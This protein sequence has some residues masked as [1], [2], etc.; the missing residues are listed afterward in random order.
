[1]KISNITSL[2]L[3]MCLCFAASA[4]ADPVN[5]PGSAAQQLSTKDGIL[6][7]SVNASFAVNE[8]IITLNEG[9]LLMR[10]KQ[11]CLVRAGAER[12]LIGPGGMCVIGRHDH[13]VTVRNLSELR[14][15]SIGVFMAD[16]MYSL[17]AAEE[18]VCAP[19]FQ[20]LKNYVLSDNVAR[21]NPRAFD[22]DC[23]HS[24]LLSEYSI[25]SLAKTNTLLR[26]VFASSAAA[27]Q[28]LR[29]EVLKMATCLNTVTG[30]RGHYMPIMNCEK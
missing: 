7:C 27:D 24:V 12:V 16:K 10:C 29:E 8:K 6:K 23:N 20:Q 4:C 13:V 26:T 14:R 28:R 17:S 21:R 18:I 25:I 15:S 9:D 5:E 2:V 11:S 22:V 3:L 30:S 1:M 19:T